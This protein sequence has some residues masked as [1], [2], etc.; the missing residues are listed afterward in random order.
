V[1]AGGLALGLVATACLALAGCSSHPKAVATTTT[2]APRS[3]DYRVGNTT[4]RAAFPGT[5][6]V[7][8]NPVS[9]TAVFPAGTKLSAWSIG[10]VG[11]L[12]VHSYELVLATFPEGSTTSTIDTF[13]S[14]YA[15]KPNTTRYGKPA[16]HTVSAIPLSTG[17]R[18]SGIAAFSVG[19]LLVIA[20][21]YDDAPAPVARWLGS[22]Q[23]VS[24]GE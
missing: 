11:A 23:L 4:V 21:G 7:Q 2:V 14:G 3:G 13:L 22:V 1:S 5:P 6:T 24:P 8:T 16:V 10:N 12:K 17:T 15:G 19:R 18:Y 20:V 9:L